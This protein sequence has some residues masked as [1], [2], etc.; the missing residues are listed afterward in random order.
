MKRDTYQKFFKASIA[1]TLVAS[2]IVVAT[3][4]EVNAQKGS[5]KGHYK[6][7]QKKYN[8]N[9]DKNDHKKGHGKYKKPTPKVDKTILQTSINN[10]KNLKKSDYTVDSWNKLQQALSAAQ[11]VLWSSKATQA[12][13]TKAVNNLNAARSN[14]VFAYQPTDVKVNTFKELKDAI[15]NP[16]VKNISIQKDIVIEEYLKIT[17]EK[18]INGNGYTLTGGVSRRGD[19]SYVLQFIK[20]VGSI[21]NIKIKGADA[22]IYVDGSTVTLSSLIDVS[23]NTVAGIIIAK[24]SGA[25]QSLMKIAN[26]TLVHRDETNNKPTILE[27]RIERTDEANR[28]AGYE[29][30]YVDYNQKAANHYQRFYYLNQTFRAPNPIKHFTLSLM[31]SN[32]THANLDQVAKKVTA[33]KEVRA[34]KPK[35][36]LV[37]AGDVFTGT[38]YF[39]DFKGQADL[40]FMNLMGYDI[41]TFGE[42]E[43]DLG[44]SAE[45]HQ[46]LVNFIKGAQFSFVSSNIDF[47]RDAKFNGLFSDSISSNPQNGKMYNGIVKQIDGEKVGFFGLT[48]EETRYISNPGAI[49]FNNYI[50]Q[51]KKAV[52]AFEKMGVNKIVAITHL[53]YNND[54]NLASAVEGIDVIVGGHSHTQLAQPIVVDQNGTPTIIVQAYQ[55]SEYLGTLNVDF[56][57]KGLVVRHDGKLI[58]IADK[59][60]DPYAAMLLK[61]YKA[62]VN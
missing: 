44:S 31:H 51:A 29:R 18:H 61:A 23:G 56:D 55:N 27:D 24:S 14:L 41:M 19:N 57:A 52:T 21:T 38:Q 22:A 40:Q 35:A 16:K 15:N 49:T 59:A 4:S 7:E 39:N 6:Q 3:P 11:I 5:G 46:A 2:A 54:L 37:D 1:M 10:L 13:V 53:G 26:A 28:V 50:E 60:E 43:F 25:N 45:G 33:V 17:S 9:K 12:D 48:T 8:N 47:S 42:H 30:M 20:T 62:R 34:A 58:K 36:L 32:D